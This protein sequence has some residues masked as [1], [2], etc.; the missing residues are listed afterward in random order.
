MAWPFRWSFGATIMARNGAFGLERDIDLPF[1]PTVGLE[2]HGVFCE[3]SQDT[4]ETAWYDVSDGLFYVIVRDDPPWDR[5]FT[6]E[7]VGRFLAHG[8]TVDSRS[9]VSDW[10]SLRAPKASEPDG[11]PRGTRE[12]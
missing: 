2:I 1:V 4:V 5:D 6:A 11:Q 8:C 10:L 7:D 9:T 12:G 3:D